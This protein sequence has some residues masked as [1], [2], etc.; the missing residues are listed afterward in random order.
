MCKTLRVLGRDSS[1]VAFLSWCEGNFDVVEAVSEGLE[2][3]LRKMFK[4]GLVEWVGDGRDAEPRQT[5]GND[6]RFLPNLTDYLR[7]TTGFILEQ[8]DECLRK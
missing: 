8:K 3:E 4:Y 7:R 6:K 1:P 5:A 2:A